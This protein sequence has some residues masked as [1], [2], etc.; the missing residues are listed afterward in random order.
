MR[1]DA[2]LL[3]HPGKHRRGAISSVADQTVR[4]ESEMLLDPIDHRLGRF[5]FLRSVSERHFDIDNNSRMQ[6]DQIVSGVSK[7]CRAARR[8]RPACGGVGR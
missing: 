8:S 1:R 6:I 3:N 2:F 5:D 7:E 4:L